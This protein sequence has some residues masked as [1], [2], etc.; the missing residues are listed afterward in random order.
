MKTPE[1]A[2][3]LREW[4]STIALVAIVVLAFLYVPGYLKQVDAE[5]KEREALLKYVRETTPEEHIERVK[6]AAQE[7]AAKDRA[8]R[9]A[10]T[11]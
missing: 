8:E 1:W 11:K 10:G 7:K 2:K 9:E 4:L 5:R 3:E 6:K